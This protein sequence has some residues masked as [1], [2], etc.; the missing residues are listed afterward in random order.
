MFLYS[1]P[2]FVLTPIKIIIRVM[3]GQSPGAAVH[4]AVKHTSIP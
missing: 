1:I 3:A 4:L 2:M